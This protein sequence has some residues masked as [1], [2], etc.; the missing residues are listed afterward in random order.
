MSDFIHWAESTWSTF[1]VACLFLEALFEHFTVYGDKAEDLGEKM[2]KNCSF[3]GTKE[4]LEKQFFNSAQ[5]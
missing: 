5:Q 1:W 4:A 3:I 2:E